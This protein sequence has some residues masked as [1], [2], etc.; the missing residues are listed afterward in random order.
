MELP[1]ICRLS[2]SQD[3]YSM[4]LHFPIVTDESFFFK[5]HVPPMLY[6]TNLK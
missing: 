4:R 1:Y 6:Q 3:G 5:G 2:E